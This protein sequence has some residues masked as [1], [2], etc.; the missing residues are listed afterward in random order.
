MA[1]NDRAATNVRRVIDSHG[2]KRGKTRGKSGL[3]VA[4]VNEAIVI[5]AMLR[6]RVIAQNFM[7]LAV[8]LMRMQAARRRERLSHLCTCQR[9]KRHKRCHEEQR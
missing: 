5:L 2:V 1:G 3:M 9:G 7:L 8:S 6:Q 4:A